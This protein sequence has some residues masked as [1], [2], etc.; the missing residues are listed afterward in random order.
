MTVRRDRPERCG[1]G[2]SDSVPDH[3]CAGSWANDQRRRRTSPEGHDA[4]VVKAA[5][6]SKLVGV[7]EDVR[8]DFDDFDEQVD[9]AATV[10]GVFAGEVKD[11]GGR[12]GA[13]EVVDCVGEQA[14]SSVGIG[15]RGAA[16][17]KRVFPGVGCSTA[18][19]V[20]K[21]DAEVPTFMRPNFVRWLVVNR[22]VVFR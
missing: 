12:K 5:Q 15:P 18:T 2:T 11:F 13:L 21:E 14:R 3:I 6:V 17:E 7:G 10:S 9:A 22:R 19:R 20:P 16:N 4:D 8:C 1:E